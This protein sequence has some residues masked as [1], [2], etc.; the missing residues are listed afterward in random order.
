MM[1]D[2]HQAY[3]GD[4]FAIYTNIKLFCTPETNTVLDVNY[5]SIKK[6]KMLIVEDAFILKRKIQQY[7]WIFATKILVD[8]R[9]QR[10]K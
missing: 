9:N 2:V 7:L 4:H 1:A 5:T 8:E 3:G 6:I 10:T